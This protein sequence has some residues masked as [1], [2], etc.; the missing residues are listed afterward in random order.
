MKNHLLRALVCSKVAREA[1]DVLLTDGVRAKWTSNMNGF[2]Y[3][4]FYGRMFPSLTPSSHSEDDLIKL[5]EFMVDAGKGPA[6]ANTK[7]SGYLYW[8]Q[9]IDHDL[10]LDLTP[11]ARA[12]SIPPENRINHRSPFFDLDSLYGDGPVN[13]AF[14]YDLTDPATGKTLPP[15]NERFL[16]GE[17]EPSKKLLD[18]PRSKIGRPLLV[19]SR[20]EEN[21]IVAQFHTLLLRFHNQVMDALDKPNPPDVG[22]L[23]APKFVQARRLVT[24]HYQYFVWHEWLDQFLDP[25]IIAEVR[26]NYPRG[27]PPGGQDFFIPIE[28]AVAAFRFGHSMVRSDYNI[29][30]RPDH[31][32]FSLSLSELLSR[33]SMGNPPLRVLEDNYLIDWKLFFPDMGKNVGHR[34][35]MHALDI[36]IAEDLHHLPGP[37]P[38]DTGPSPRLIQSLP[39]MTLLRG[40]RSGLPS[41][42]HI[43]DALGETRLTDDEILQQE[44]KDWDPKL[45]DFLLQRNFVKDTPLWFYILQEAA[46]V[47]TSPRILL[48]PV[49]SRI[50]A[51]V[52]VGAL[53]ADPNSIFNAGRGWTPPAWPALSSKPLNTMSEL[54]IALT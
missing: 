16:L 50:V 51:E 29:S 39:A 26:A 8:G 28:F 21:L 48:G 31:I 5:A 4:P 52:L 33:N 9:F 19:D 22:L 15:G 14:L 10:T 20:N 46:V 32:P 30:I 37:V 24:W 38:I 6:T 36:L 45:K 2:G 42:Q 11:L 17:T 41:G 53:A 54:I 47:S 13:T 18:L 3:S 44:P 43:A 12:G 35:V 34:N 7:L 49:G 25:D 27:D 40:Q 1:S 23:G